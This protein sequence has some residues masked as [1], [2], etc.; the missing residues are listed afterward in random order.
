MSEHLTEDV[1][2]IV[3]DNLGAIPDVKIEQEG[4]V[5]PLVIALSILHPEQEIINVVQQFD[6][7]GRGDSNRSEMIKQT[8][9]F[10]VGGHL[11]GVPIMKDEQR[12]P[13]KRSM[14]KAKPLP[15]GLKT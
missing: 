7:F 4:G 6:H 2:V 3:A 9:M 12:G 1:E 8:R 10:C 14:L 15:I 11:A 5:Y 13:S